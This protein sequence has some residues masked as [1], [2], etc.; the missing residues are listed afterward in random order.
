MT[1][2][3]FFDTAERGALTL[4]LSTNDPFD[5]VY[6]TQDGVP[7][8]LV[9][10]RK[11]PRSSGGSSKSGLGF[12]YLDA[13][14]TTIK[15]VRTD[16]PSSS[17]ASS[18]S[19]NKPDSHAARRNARKSWPPRSYTNR[20]RPRR[21]APHLHRRTRSSSMLSTSTPLDTID[22]VADG[23]DV[24]ADRGECSDDSGRSS[25]SGS[26]SE[27]ASRSD[28]SNNTILVATIERRPFSLSPSRLR[29]NGC[30]GP[31]SK[32]LQRERPFS[33]SG[34]R[35]PSYPTLLFSSY[36]NTTRSL[37]FSRT[38]LYNSNKA[39]L[40]KYCAPFLPSKDMLS[41]SHAVLEIAQG[42][43]SDRALDEIIVTLLL[44]FLL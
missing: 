30:E 42:I 37:T 36:L 34:S 12:G 21:G 38:Q 6:L 19:V 17:L 4:T 35:R 25:G 10:T 2:S 18:A 40:A 29:F 20:Q 43:E 5:A 16:P 22:E 9:S 23:A 41:S 26:D 13:Q 14:V 39:R 32:F 24:D 28:S 8:Y 3:S 44:T 11:R 15:R 1:L 27:P 7:L 31:A 33:S